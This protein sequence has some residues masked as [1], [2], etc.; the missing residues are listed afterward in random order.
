MIHLSKYSINPDAIAYVDWEYTPIPRPSEKPQKYVSVY[1]SV[2][3]AYI[4]PHT[5]INSLT[6]NPFHLN[7]PF[8]SEDA[9]KLRE[10]LRS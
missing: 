9:N 10:I 2:P 7:I 3:Q 1:F 5:G 8:D 6:V 4:S